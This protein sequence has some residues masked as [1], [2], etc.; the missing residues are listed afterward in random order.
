M[1]I[2]MICSHHPC[3]H[4]ARAA[5]LSLCSSPP[6]ANRDI[7]HQPSELLPAPAWLG[8]KLHKLIFT[9]ISASNY[10]FYPPCKAYNPFG[11]LQL[12]NL[13]DLMLLLQQQQSGH[14]FSFPD[15][16]YEKSFT[17]SVPVNFKQYQKS[18]RLPC[19]FYFKFQQYFVWWIGGQVILSEVGFVVKNHL[20]DAFVIEM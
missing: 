6:V 10:G 3:A 12:Q 5:M 1:Q 11:E 7:Y 15:T 18:F 16:S 13:V 4:Q 14:Q 20:T 17:R 19:R 8:N 9:T 2:S